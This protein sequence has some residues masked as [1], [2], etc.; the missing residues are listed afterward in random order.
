MGSNPSGPCPDSDLGPVPCIVETV[1]PFIHRGYGEGRNPSK[2]RKLWFQPVDHEVDDVPSTLVAL[3]TFLCLRDAS[4][5]GLSPDCTGMGVL[6]CGFGLILVSRPSPCQVSAPPTQPPPA[7]SHPGSLL[8]IMV[9]SWP[10]G[11]CPK[12]HHLCCPVHTCVL[13]HSLILWPAPRRESHLFP[14]GGV[15]RV[16]EGDTKLLFSP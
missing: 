5:T 6:R 10:P 4:E 16:R 12:A 11:L 14:E 2:P 8:L 13:P 9:T 7:T 1:S 3:C 15:S